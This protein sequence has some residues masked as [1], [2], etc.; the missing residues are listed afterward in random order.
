M[1]SVIA[2]L[3]DN[4]CPSLHGLSPEDTYEL[5]LRLFVTKVSMCEYGLR[6]LL[7]RYTGS[8]YAVF[9]TLFPDQILEW[10]LNG[11]KDAW[12][13]EPRETAARAIR[14]LFEDYLRIPVDELPD[15]AT[16]RL[17]WDVGFSGILTNRRIGFNSSTFDAVDNAYPGRFSRDD[18]SQFRR[19][20][21]FGT[22][23]L[24]KDRVT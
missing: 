9:K 13:H 17:F 10:T 15:Y 2:Y 14:W 21:G 18:F 8:T 11:S 23:K 12:R 5:G 4:D 6:A 22:K 24:K 1:D 19:T 16:N 3:N 7:K 20:K